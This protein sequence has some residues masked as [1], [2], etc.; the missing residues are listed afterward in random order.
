M[1]LTGERK[2]YVAILGLGLVGL[3]LNRAFME[4]QRASAA[5]DSATPDQS[6]LLVN[7]S[8]K[9]RARSEPRQEGPTLS[10]RMRDAAMRTMAGNDQVVDA[11]DPHANQ[12]PV[13]T[14]TAAPPTEAELFSQAHKLSAIVTTDKGGAA[15]VDGKTILVGHAIQG[16]TLTRVDDD[17]AHFERDGTVVLLKRPQRM[18]KDGSH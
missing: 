16:F 1:K 5:A 13:L 4:P 18:L 12:T 15:I 17:G 11:F 9:P 8:A 3:V 7:D 6:S 14:P 2:V 10:S